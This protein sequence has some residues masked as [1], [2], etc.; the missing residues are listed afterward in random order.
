M[1]AIFRIWL[2]QFSITFFLSAFGVRVIGAPTPYLAEFAARSVIRVPSIPPFF[3]EFGHKRCALKFEG[4]SF[5]KQF[6]VVGSK[7]GF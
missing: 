5:I 1:S 7:R 3:W 2:A 6:S 4:A